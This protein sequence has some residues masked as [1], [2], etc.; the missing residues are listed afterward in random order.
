MK[1][2]KGDIFL[3]R[4]NHKLYIFD[5]SEWWEIIPTSYLKKFDWIA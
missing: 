2:K 4:D 5:G 1:Y 3:S